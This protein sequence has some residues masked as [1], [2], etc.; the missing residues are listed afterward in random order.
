MFGL[1]VPLWVRWA[2]LAAFFAAA[3]GH[4][5]V[6]GVKHEI[7]RAAIVKAQFDGFVGQTGAIGKAAQKAV[8]AREKSNQILK[9]QSDHENS[10][11]SAAAAADAHQLRD[12]RARGSFVPI[13]PPGAGSSDRA[14]FDR[15]ILEQAVQRLD[16]EV[17]GL[18][19]KCDQAVIDLNTAKRWNAELKRADA[20]TVR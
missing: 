5:Y 8:E 9:E 13:K 7:A 20:M 2:A 15:A 11:I 14:C 16:D 3:W 10:R 1:V 19:A 18:F 4:G 12:A 17:S 6:T